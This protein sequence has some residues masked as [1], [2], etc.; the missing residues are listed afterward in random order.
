MKENIKQTTTNL[1]RNEIRRVRLQDK[2][3][4]RNVG[5]HLARRSLSTPGVGDPRCKAYVGVRK[6]EQP[7]LC[8]APCAGKAVTV[9]LVVSRQQLKTSPSQR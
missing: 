1:V 4:E 9:N 2:S 3:V 5:R 6:A 7:M 8:L